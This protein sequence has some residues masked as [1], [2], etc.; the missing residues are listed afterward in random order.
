MRLLAGVISGTVLLGL[1]PG[2]EAMLIEIYDKPTFLGSTGASS[3]TGVLPDLGFVGV[4]TVI[5]GTTISITAPSS[6][7]YVGAAGAGIGGDW[8]GPLLGNDIAIS[9]R[10]NLNFDLPGARFSFGL[11]SWSLAPRCR[12]G[13]ARPTPPSRSR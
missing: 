13:A 11:T 2:A 4:A 10:E 3:I 5:S 1:V 8:Y 12:R 9:D 6:A 7:L